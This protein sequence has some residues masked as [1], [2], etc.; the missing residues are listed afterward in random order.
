VPVISVPVIAV[1]VI[2]VPKYRHTNYVLSIPNG[3]ERTTFI[4]GQS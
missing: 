4:A 1:P 2:N 3:I